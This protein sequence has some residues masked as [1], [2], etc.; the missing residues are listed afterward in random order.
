MARAQLSQGMR[1]LAQRANIPSAS[2]QVGVAGGCEIRTREGLHP[3]RFPS[4]HCYLTMTAAGRNGGRVPCR[5][6]LPLINPRGTGAIWLRSEASA[7][8]PAGDIRASV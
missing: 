5:W 1:H 2:P 6:V 3:T 7:I 8:W 4:E